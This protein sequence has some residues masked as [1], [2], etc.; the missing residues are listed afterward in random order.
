M[1]EARR[2]WYQQHE[3]SWLRLAATLRA[4]GWEAQLTSSAA[5]VQLEG[6]LP[7][8]ERFYFRSRHADAS[9]GIGGDDPAD[10]PEWEGSESHQE[11]G[12]LP[13][14]AGEAIIRRLLRRYLGEHRRAGRADQ[15]GDRPH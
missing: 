1:N 3:A 15:N 5:P 11:A 9:L 7:G 2:R 10:L 13:A 12:Y 4:E 6:A 14:A 8:G